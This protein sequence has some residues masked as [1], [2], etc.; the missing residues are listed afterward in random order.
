VVAVSAYVLAV[1]LGYVPTERKIDT[2]SLAFIALAVFCVFLIGNPAVFEKLK[3]LEFGG[4]KLEM[5]EKVKEV[6]AKQAEQ[7]NKINKIEDIGL[8]LPLLLPKNEQKHLLNLAN[9][10]TAEFKLPDGT[11]AEIKGSPQLQTELRHLRKV[12]AIRSRPGFRIRDI[13]NEPKID[14]AR[15]VELTELGERLARR[16]KEVEAKESQTE[17]KPNAA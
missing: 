17:N 7:E 8:V 5:L 1:V 6:K 14:L 4:L 10:T 12:T 15:Y 3:S 9:G 16:I 13:V 11:T 2:A